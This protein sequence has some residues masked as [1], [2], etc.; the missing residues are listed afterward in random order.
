MALFT[1]PLSIAL[2][3]LIH[4]KYQKSAGLVDYKQLKDTDCTV[5]CTVNANYGT[6][7]DRTPPEV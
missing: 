2:L 6:I 5:L 7:S 1:E 3:A 4:T